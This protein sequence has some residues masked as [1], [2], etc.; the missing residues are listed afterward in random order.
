M[1]LPCN[2]NIA[3]VIG[4]N[5]IYQRFFTLSD[6]PEGERVGEWEGQGCLMIAVLILKECIACLNADN[7]NYG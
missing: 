5:C 1:K 3:V 6:G 7:E 2:G 4:Y